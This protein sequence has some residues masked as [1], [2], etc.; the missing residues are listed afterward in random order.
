V[1]GYR[2]AGRAAPGTAFPPPA[3]DHACDAVCEAE[4][5]VRRGWESV[6]LGCRE[7]MESAVQAAL[8]DCST[9]YRLV[10]QAQR[11]GDPGEIITARIH[12]HETVEAARGSLTASQSIRHALLARMAEEHDSTA[13][14]HQPAWV[15]PWLVV[16]P[17]EPAEPPATH[18]P[19][20]AVVA[21]RLRRVPAWALRHLA[22]TRGRGQTAT[23]LFGACWSGARSNSTR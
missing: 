5:V 12:L 1:F 18:K 17:A 7:Q 6:L 16:A 2:R 13:H 21:R 20:F 14:A 22:G 8:A 15:G 23:R 10:A 9:A 3:V 19:R 11:G 4:N